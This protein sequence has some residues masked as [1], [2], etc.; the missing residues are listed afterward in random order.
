MNSID[1]NCIYK[2]ISILGSLI[3]IDNFIPTS[4]DPNNP[5]NPIVNEISIPDGKGGIQQP[6]SK[7]TLTSAFA[8]ISKNT[9]NILNNK[10]KMMEQIKEKESNLINDIHEVYEYDLNNNINYNNYN[11][12]NK[13]EKNKNINN[14]IL[15]I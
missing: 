14:D 15:T 7:L 9:D 11:N 10:K 5:F 12:F 4:P 8:E 6:T 2:L 13:K 3:N 1:L